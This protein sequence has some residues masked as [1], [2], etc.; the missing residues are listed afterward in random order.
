MA[1]EP[2]SDDETLVRLVHPSQ[3]KDGS[4]TSAVFKGSRPLSFFV[5]ER[6][7]NGD[8]EVLHVG[9]FA[10]HGRLT[11]GVRTVRLLAAPDGLPYGFVVELDPQG[12]RPPLAVYAEAHA[13]VRGP[14]GLAPWKTLLK[15]AIREGG[16]SKL[17]VS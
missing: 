11:V 7:P 4:P 6:L 17:P 9:P 12:A 3:V 5:I 14:D 16:L 1:P 2:I 10:T 13:V 8:P 15:Q